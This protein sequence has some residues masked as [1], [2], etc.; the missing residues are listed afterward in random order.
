MVGFTLT[1]GAAR[2]T[3]SVGSRRRGVLRIHQRRADQLRA[4]AATRAI[5]FGGGAY[6]G[7]LNN[8]TL[9]GNTGSDGGGADLLHAQQLHADWQLGGGSYGGGA[10]DCTLNN[11]TLTGNS[12][13]RRRR[14]SGCTLNNCT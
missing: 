11:C 8:C 6:G 3:G 12:A 10:F 7:T 5:M 9:T 13:D 2:L 4:D 1:N 14:G